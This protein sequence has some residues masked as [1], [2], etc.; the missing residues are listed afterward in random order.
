MPVPLR[1]FNSLEEWYTE[2]TSDLFFN[3]NNYLKR[4]EDLK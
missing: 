3:K 2:W 1:I 4:N